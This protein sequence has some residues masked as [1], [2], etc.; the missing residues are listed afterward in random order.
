MSAAR[1]IVSA[2]GLV[3]DLRA[4]LREHLHADDVDF[5][6][7]FIVDACTHY[8]RRPKG[9][10]WHPLDPWLSGEID[11]ARQ[12][13]DAHDL[14][15]LTQLRDRT[16]PRRGR[17]PKIERDWLIHDLNGV[18]PRR[19]ARKSSGRA[20]ERTVA[21]ALRIAGHEIPADDPDVEYRGLHEL[22]MDVLGGVDTPPADLNPRIEG[23][24]LEWLCGRCSP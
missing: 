3:A 19:F 11:R 1:P 22:I 20:F 24:Y 13:H 10:L 14:L 9:E 6:H 2:D 17:S 15:R 4:H 16:R 5:V 7:W 18:F 12:S 23:A 8:R 21:L